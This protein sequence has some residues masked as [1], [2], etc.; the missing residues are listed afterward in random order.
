MHPIEQSHLQREIERSNTL[1]KSLSKNTNK[2]NSLLNIKR[3]MII[4]TQLFQQNANQMIPEHEM[5]LAA[6]HRLVVCMYSF[7]KKEENGTH[8]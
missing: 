5:I 6:Y 1:A 2:Q 8:D 4:L 3:A 7:F